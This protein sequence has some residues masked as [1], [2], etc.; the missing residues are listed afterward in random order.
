MDETDWLVQIYEL[1]NGDAQDLVAGLLAGVDDLTVN[2]GPHGQDH[3][4]TIV[5]RDTSKAQSVYRLVTSVDPRAVL[6][7]SSTEQALAPERD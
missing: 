2:A 1:T 4:V 5:L 6:I 7:H 3:F